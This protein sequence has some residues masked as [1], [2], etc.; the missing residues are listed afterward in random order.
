MAS[1]FGG[2]ERHLRPEFM[3]QYQPIVELATGRIV[4]V[5]AL[6]RWQHPK[7]G[8]IDPD[9]FIRVA[10]DSDAILGIGRWVLSEACRQV[11]L[12][13][14]VTPSMP[15]TVSVNVSARELIQ[16]AFVDQ[17]LTIIRQAGV[18]PADIVLEMTETSDAQDWEA[19]RAKL[20][21]LR[22]AQIGISV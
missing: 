17:V 20:E 7:R 10:E 21:A 11:H 13:R 3:L 16:P 15:F 8:R 2:P 22:N 4:G 1:G 6:L 18:D 5:E 12:C 9:E 14:A 19:T